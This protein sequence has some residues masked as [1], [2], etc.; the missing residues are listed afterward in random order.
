[1]QYYR[2]AIFLTALTQSKKI[3]LGEPV[4]TEQPKK[5]VAAY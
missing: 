5:S 2:Y 3:I 1:M 4:T